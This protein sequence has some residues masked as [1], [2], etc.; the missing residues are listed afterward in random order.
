MWLCM[1]YVQSCI[2]INWSIYVNSFKLTT[3]ERFDK[4]LL[5]Q[6]WQLQV[7][8]FNTPLPIMA[9]YHLKPQFN[10]PSYISFLKILTM[11]CMHSN[12]WLI[13]HKFPLVRSVFSQA[14]HHIA[15]SMIIDHN[16]WALSYIWEKNSFF[17]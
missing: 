11:Q 13:I 2:F 12:L 15:P 8:L 1:K 10:T 14:Y 16:L 3:K 17:F 9:H 7:I 4:S 5:S 6:V